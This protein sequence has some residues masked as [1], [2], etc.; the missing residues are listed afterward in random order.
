MPLPLKKWFLNR[1]YEQKEN[2]IKQLEESHKKL[3]N[4]KGI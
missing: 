1:L 2:E 4:K 3:K